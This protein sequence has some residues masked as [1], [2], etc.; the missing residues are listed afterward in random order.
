[1]L[2][3]AVIGVGNMG[4]H[5]ARVYS[6]IRGVKLVALSDINIDS[7]RE[8]AIKFGCRAYRDYREMIKNESLDMVSIVV[9]TKLHKRVS[10]DTIGAGIHTLVEKPI[11]DNTKD[12]K[13]IVLAARNNGVKLAVGHIERFNP[14]VTQL[15]KLVA[16]GSLGKISSI[17]AKR[18]GY[19]PSAPIDVNVL[20]E[21]GIHDI[22]IFNYILG[23][24]PEVVYASGGQASAGK[25]KEDYVNV[26]LGYNGV[27][28]LLEVNW[29]TPLKI[30]RL[31]VTGSEAFAELDYISQDLVVHHV[32]KSS[33][34]DSK[35][36][37]ET[38]NIVKK[39]PLK[40][41]LEHFS[42]CIV[43]NKTPLN[44]GKSAYEALRI[45]Q[46][47]IEFLNKNK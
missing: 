14:A 19:F 29:I 45:A 5:H 1:M 35:R 42:E 40:L 46:K 20:I 2:N 33:A 23:G 10:M 37:Y 30:R 22:D 24:L 12:A 34:H 32:N 8:L 21:V 13:D 18:V 47:A 15:K 28:A 36:I 17:M 38:I 27:S 41:E 4:R 26:L 3:A 43:N 6:E 44:D 25:H 39:E 7:T 16:S 31:E 9:P 11:A